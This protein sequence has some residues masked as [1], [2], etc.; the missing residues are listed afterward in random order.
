MR[1]ELEILTQDPLSKV[2]I[3]FVKGVKFKLAYAQKLSEKMSLKSFKK[4]S[5]KCRKTAKSL[6]QLLSNLLNQY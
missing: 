2:V 5:A 6:M 1:V 4:L 3:K